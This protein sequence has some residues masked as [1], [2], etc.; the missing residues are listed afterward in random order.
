MLEK[1]DL[2]AIEL[3]ARDW[4]EDFDYEPRYPVKAL[5]GSHFSEFRR[6]P[7]HELS[8]WIRP[9]S[10]DEKEDVFAEEVAKEKARLLSAYNETQLSDMDKFVLQIK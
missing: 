1:S 2:A 8:Q 3:I 6:W 10:F 7:T 9:Y 4:M 5:L